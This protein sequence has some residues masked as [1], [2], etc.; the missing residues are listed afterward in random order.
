MRVMLGGRTENREALSLL[1]DLS[2]GVSAYD[3][4]DAGVLTVYVAPGAGEIDLV[5]AL[6]TS[7]MYPLQTFDID[8]HNQGGPGAC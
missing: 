1:L 3:I 8:E 4:D 6:A 2:E 5:R 7:G